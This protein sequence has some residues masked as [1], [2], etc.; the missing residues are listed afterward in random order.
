MTEIHIRSADEQ[1][2]MGATH[3]D[4]IDLI[5]SPRDGLLVIVAVKGGRHVCQLCG[6]TFDQSSRLLRGVEVSFS[7]GSPKL[8]MHSGCESRK[9]QVQN[10]FRGLEFRRKLA[11]IARQSQSIEAASVDSNP[12]LAG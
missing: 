11:S 5:Q 10:K 8:L 4:D 6:G 1:A 2:A 3:M 12:K 7:P 9:A